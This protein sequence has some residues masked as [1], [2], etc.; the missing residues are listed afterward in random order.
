MSHNLCTRLSEFFLYLVIFLNKFV[1]VFY[2]VVDRLL[3]PRLGTIGVFPTLILGER[4]LVMLLGAST[5]KQEL[6]YMKMGLVSIY[7]VKGCR[8]FLRRHDLNSKM[9]FV[10]WQLMTSLI[11]SGNVKLLEQFLNIL[12]LFLSSS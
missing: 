2:T 7:Y 4:D 6:I 10:L 1:W 12:S 8:T 3:A 9:W 11:M 5:V